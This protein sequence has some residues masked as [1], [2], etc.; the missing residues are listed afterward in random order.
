[1]TNIKFGIIAITLFTGAVIL[2]FIQIVIEIIR[3]FLPHIAVHLEQY[4]IGSYF[5]VILFF[6]ERLA[7]TKLHITK[8]TLD[9]L[10]NEAVI[11]ICNHVS[12]ADWVIF[13]MLAARCRRLGVIKIAAKSLVKLIP[14]FGWAAW[15][16]RFPVLNKSWDSDEKTLTDCC[17][18]YQF[19]NDCGLPFWVCIFPEGT[20][21]DDPM[22]KIIKETEKFC[23]S[24]L[25]V[26]THT[27][28]PRIKGVTHLMD[29]LKM[30]VKVVDL[31]I[32]YGYPYETALPLTVKRKI[33]TITSYI[34]ES[35]NVCVAAREITPI[36]NWLYK[37]F[38]EKNITL[39]N[40]EEVDVFESKAPTLTQ[41]I[42]VCVWAI[43]LYLT[44]PYF[45]FGAMAIATIAYIINAVTST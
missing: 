32:W 23:G 18:Y 36:N 25:A 11:V 20:F 29:K 2:N 19:M 13:A 4:F 9:L 45:K 21:V 44:P 8:H 28:L 12:Y 43:I 38:E 6:F 16:G 31:T 34:C 3:L 5:N 27:L 35:V 26:P 1:M 40:I 41:N 7:R 30:P 15:L 39:S 24:K 22:D 10:S 14:G 17:N 33:P 37:V 42:D